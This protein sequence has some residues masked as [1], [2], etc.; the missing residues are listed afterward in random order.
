MEDGGRDQYVID[1]DGENK[2]T[3]RVV[4]EVNKEGF[5][6]GL[7]IIKKEIPLYFWLN[8]CIGHVLRWKEQTW[9][10][11]DFPRIEGREKNF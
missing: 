8:N 9:G 1:E 3:F 7:D 5:T 10:G 11:I 4:F 2:Y 6:V